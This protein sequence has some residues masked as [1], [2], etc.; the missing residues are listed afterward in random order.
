MK[1]AALLGCFTEINT[2][3]RMQDITKFSLKAQCTFCGGRVKPV[4]LPCFSRAGLARE[5][6]TSLS[7]PLSADKSPESAREEWW[8]VATL[9][10]EEHLSRKDSAALNLNCQS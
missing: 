5:L 8:W 4:T 9:G 1:E 3:N 10:E 6:H 7:H 2:W